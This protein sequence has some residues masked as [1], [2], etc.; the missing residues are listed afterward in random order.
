MGFFKK[1][2]RGLGKVT[3]N[4]GKGI[5]GL[6][7]GIFG[8]DPL[9][10]EN[11]PSSYSLNHNIN[12][13]S[14]L[15]ITANINAKVDVDVDLSDLVSA[16]ALF[17]DGMIQFDIFGGALNKLLNI[18]ENLDNEKGMLK[19]LS[20][21]IEKGSSALK[22]DNYYF[23]LSLVNDSTS[24]EQ[25]SYII[26]RSCGLSLSISVNNNEIIHNMGLS[27]KNNVGSSSNEVTRI[28]KIIGF[29]KVDEFNK[30]KI[31]A[32][33]FMGVL[34]KDKAA[35][36]KDC[37][38]QV[39]LIRETPHWKYTVLEW[40]FDGNSGPSKMETNF[41]AGSSDFNPSP[42]K[43][44]RSLELKEKI[45][46]LIHEIYSPKLID[47]KAL[48]EL[49]KETVMTDMVNTILSK[50]N[51]NINKKFEEID[52]F[53]ETFDN[54]DGS[55]DVRTP[56]MAS[57]SCHK[58]PIKLKLESGTVSKNTNIIDRE[59]ILNEGDELTILVPLLA[60][61]NVSRNQIKK[62]FIRYIL[63]SEVEN[64]Y[65]TATVYAGFEWDNEI[66]SALSFQPVINQEKIFEVPIEL[67]DSLS[68]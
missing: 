11:I 1:I 22:E 68:Q 13:K 49:P 47:E 20:H 15:D 40:I 64:A 57:F 44:K 6:V 16:A 23:E 52:D 38:L 12:S 14:E 36:I 24:F 67:S 39:R 48:P 3:K 45:D 43:S 59:M 34:E 65:C 66:V 28:K 10:L 53:L 51:N 26:Q 5:G 35:W 54:R 41:F 8:N 4:I 63:K 56:I 25:R 27:I 58:G 37:R 17:R 30:I 31:S 60:G 29:S 61:S 55:Y 18:N 9:G 2:K 32:D 33:Y 42:I 7:R 21:V 50:R 62:Q 46:G 19:E